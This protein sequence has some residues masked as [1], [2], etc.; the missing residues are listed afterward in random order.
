M[1]YGSQ[2]KQMQRKINQIGPLKA[3]FHEHLKQRDIPSVLAKL[4]C[5][6]V[7]LVALS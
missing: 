3:L 6:G 4:T 1:A 2:G 7:W 5:S